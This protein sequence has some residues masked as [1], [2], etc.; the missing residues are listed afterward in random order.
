VNDVDK[1]FTLFYVIW[2]F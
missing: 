2:R 1:A